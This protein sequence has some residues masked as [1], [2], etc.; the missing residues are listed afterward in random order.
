MR[1][2]SNFRLRGEQSEKR[3][4]KNTEIMQVVYSP[5]V[6]LSVYLYAI[7][8]SVRLSVCLSVCPPIIC[9][10]GWLYVGLPVCLSTCQSVLPVYLS[11]R[12]TV[13]ILFVRWLTFCLSV[14]LS[15]WLSA[16]LPVYP[17]ACL[18]V[19][20]SCPPPCLS[21]NPPACLS[22]CLSV[23]LTAYLHMPVWPVCLPALE[24]K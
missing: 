6:R 2:L 10:T 22:V 3:L 5:S 13:C 16:R 19:C 9:L 15:V 11:V 12:L 21:V 20:L 23:Y 8:L 14:P 18:S 7:F 24:R 4:R 17:S 1:Q